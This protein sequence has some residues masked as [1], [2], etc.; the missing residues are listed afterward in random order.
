MSFTTDSTAGLPRKRNAR[1][2]RPPSSWTDPQ[3]GTL[4]HVCSDEKCPVHA[5]EARYQPT[6]QERAIRAKELLAERV[7]KQTRVRILDASRKKLLASLPLFELEMVALDYFGR[8][9]YDNHCRISHIY[10]WEKN[11]PKTSWGGSSLDYQTV[12]KKA[13][14]AMSPTEVQHFLVACALVSDLCCPGYNPRQS[15]AKDSN[16]ARAAARYKIDP[17][18]LAAAVSEELSKEVGKRKNLRP[19]NKTAR[20]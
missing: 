2:R 9:G 11:K 17:A 20:N 19:K 13:V 5:H 3:A 8:I 16:L 4:L 6:P 14:G 7:E 15:L 1:K 12:A 10:E 18:K